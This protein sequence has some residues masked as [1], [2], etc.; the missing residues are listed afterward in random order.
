MASPTQSQQ[1]LR[2][3]HISEAPMKVR[4]NNIDMELR[5]VWEEMTCCEIPIR[6][7][8][9]DDNIDLARVWEKER[10]N[11]EKKRILEAMALW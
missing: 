10:K 6:K 11:I 4:G 2:R 8:G 1:G 9:I 5:M 7:Y 3:F